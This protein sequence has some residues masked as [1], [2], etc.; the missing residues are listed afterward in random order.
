MAGTG[1]SQAR[2]VFK[3]VKD[4]R[5]TAKHVVVVI[6]HGDYRSTIASLMTSTPVLTDMYSI[7][8]AGPFSV[9][10]KNIEGGLSGARKWISSRHLSRLYGREIKIIWASDS[11]TIKNKSSSTFSNQLDIM[12]AMFGT[13]RYKLVVVLEG[14]E[15]P[16]QIEREDYNKKQ[17]YH[18]IVVGCTQIEQVQL[19]LTALDKTGAFTMSDIDLAGTGMITAW[20]NEKIILFGRTGSG[21]STVA[22]MLTQGSLD[23]CSN[24]ISGSSA[25]G[26]TKDVTSEQGRGW[27]VTDTPGFGE[28]K[29]EG[30]VPTE[31]A[32]QKLKTFMSKVGGTHAHF[33]CVIRHGR[34]DYYDEMLWKFFVKLL[35]NAEENLSI[36]VTCCET[37]L[38]ESDKDDLRRRFNE[39]KRFTWVNFKTLSDEYKK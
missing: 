30:T 23:S 7:V 34:I 20:S 26:V 25:K 38:S 9:S 13:K 14:N 22:R 18:N 15:I 36:V 21:K 33:I 12:W 2:S 19:V 1:H 3:Q 28:T 32:I 8:D 27:F 39:C 24:F 11:D 4:A 37:G 16:K 31:A 5:D 17:D 6:G 35:P 10:G 29:T